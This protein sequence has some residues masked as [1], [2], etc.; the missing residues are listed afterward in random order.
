[1]DMRRRRETVRQ[2]DF[3][4]RPIR[5]LNRR[6]DSNQIEL[7]CLECWSAPS[8]SLKGGGQSAVLNLLKDFWCPGHA[9]IRSTH[10]VSIRQRKAH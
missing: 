7:I 10:I 5:S 6:E 3:R 9:C 2:R 8:W 4:N 1:M